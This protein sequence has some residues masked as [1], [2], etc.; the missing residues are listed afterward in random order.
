LKRET[1]KEKRIESAERDA[2]NTKRVYEVKQICEKV[3]SVILVRREE[4]QKL[5]IK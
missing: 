2:G 1:L 4:A 3:N 5:R